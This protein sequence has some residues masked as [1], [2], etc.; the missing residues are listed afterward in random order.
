MN[1]KTPDTH[2]TDATVKKPA[3]KV[4]IYLAE[5]DANGLQS[6]GPYRVGQRHDNV[7]AAVAEALAQRF[8]FKV[9]STTFDP[10]DKE[11]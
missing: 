5:K 7:D 3:A 4:S 9:V 2:K 10:S 1:I 6:A 8:G 11:G